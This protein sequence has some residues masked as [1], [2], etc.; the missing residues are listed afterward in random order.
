MKLLLHTQA[1]TYTEG[2]KGIRLWRTITAFITFPI[3]LG[4][5]CV[6]CALKASRRR[7]DIC[8]PSCQMTQAATTLVLFFTF[9]ATI[10]LRLTNTHTRTHIHIVHTSSLLH[11]FR[12]GHSFS[13]LEHRNIYSS[14]KS[15]SIS[16]SFSN[17]PLRVP[18]LP[19]PP[20][21]FLPLHDVTPLHERCSLRQIRQT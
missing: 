9:L 1:H 2:Q 11:V 15:D 13:G 21:P 16:T 17:P 3:L 12:I 14:N 5:P 18:S 20:Q 8:G 6:Y 4:S 7:L 10:S 19:I